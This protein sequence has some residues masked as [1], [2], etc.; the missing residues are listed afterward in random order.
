MLTVTITYIGEDCE[1]RIIQ[2][3]WPETIAQVAKI[4][5]AEYDRRAERAN[6]KVLAA[7]LRGEE[8]T[9]RSALRA[10]GVKLD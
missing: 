2:T 8:R 7:L 4:I 6:D 3:F 10:A 1:P 5:L 9:A